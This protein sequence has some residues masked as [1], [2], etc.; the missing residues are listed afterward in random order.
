MSVEPPSTSPV[1]ADI[2][3][4]LLFLIHF[5]IMESVTVGKKALKQFM[6]VHFLSFLIFFLSY[7]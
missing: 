4:K 5:K 1:A 2:D 3:M 6:I 7:F